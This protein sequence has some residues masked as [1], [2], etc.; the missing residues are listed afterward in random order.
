V[1][2][3][4]VRQFGQVIVGSDM[5]VSRS[6]GSNRLQTVPVIPV[7]RDLSRL[8]VVDGPQVTDR[9]GGSFGRIGATGRLQT[10]PDFSAC[11]HKRWPVVVAMAGNR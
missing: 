11:L 1:S 3:I 5:V 10:Q 7:D 6:C 2:L 9:T 8:D 4:S